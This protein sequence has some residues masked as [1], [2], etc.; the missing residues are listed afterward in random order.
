MYR[1]FCEFCEFIEEQTQDL[2]QVFKNKFNSIREYLNC[3]NYKLKKHYI[4]IYK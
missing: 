3:N 1:L 2:C 4:Y